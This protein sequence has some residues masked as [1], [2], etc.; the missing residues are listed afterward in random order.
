VP[1]GIP[2]DY[3]ALH[4]FVGDNERT[5]VVAVRYPLIEQFVILRLRDV[6]RARRRLA[7]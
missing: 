5:M 4:H 6:H 2:P 7:L 3:E 1:V